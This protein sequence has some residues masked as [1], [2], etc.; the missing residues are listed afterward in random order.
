MINNYFSCLLSFQAR[1]QSLTLQQCQDLLRRCLLRDPSLI[2]IYRPALLF[3]QVLWARAPP[4]LNGVSVWGPG[5]CPLMLKRSAVASHHNTAFPCY[6]IWT[7]TFSMRVFLAWPGESGMTP[8]T[9]MWASSHEGF[10][11]PPLAIKIRNRI[12]NSLHVEIFKI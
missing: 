5:K 8:T 11:Q 10:Y 1:I 6:L 4:S 2:L 3:L 7:F 9:N 12:V